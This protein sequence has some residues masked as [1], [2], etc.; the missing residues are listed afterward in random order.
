VAALIV[1]LFAPLHVVGLANPRAAVASRVCSFCRR[2]ARA[3]GA[4]MILR[5]IDRRLDRGM[6]DALRLQL[7]IDHQHPL[8]L[9]MHGATEVNG[10]IRVAQIWESDWYAKRFDE[11][12]LAPALEAVGAPVDAE[13][14]VYQLEHL[15]TP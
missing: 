10:L 12:I 7:D 2:A 15:V 1:S 5:I 6:Y 11:E 8:G 9:I 14:A 4:N 13:M 3:G